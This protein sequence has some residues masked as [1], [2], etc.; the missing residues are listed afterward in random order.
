MTERPTEYVT[1]HVR[2]PKKL[3]QMLKQRAAKENTSMARLISDSL[4]AYL[5]R[6]LSLA[7]QE[8]ETVDPVYRLSSLAAEE[9]VIDNAPHDGSTNHDYYVYQHEYERW[10]NEEP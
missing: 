6:S 8:G 5:T 9:D 2:L 10:H 3:H 1:T 7:P 4:V